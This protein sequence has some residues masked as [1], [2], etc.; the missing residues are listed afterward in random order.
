MQWA[1]RRN[2]G[3]DDHNNNIKQPKFINLFI[4]NILDSFAH[5]TNDKTDK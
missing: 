4:I 5:F 1:M 3:N 2:L